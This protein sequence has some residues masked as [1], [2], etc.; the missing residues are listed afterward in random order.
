[1]STEM[2][3]RGWPLAQ[4]GDARPARRLR[5]C[6]DDYTANEIMEVNPPFAKMG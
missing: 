5:S 3:D 2:I 6:L 4:C 1:M